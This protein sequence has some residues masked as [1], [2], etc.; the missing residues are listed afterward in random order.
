VTTE[1]STASISFWRFHHAAGN[2]DVPLTINYVAGQERV[3]VSLRLTPVQ[4]AELCT[5]HQVTEVHI[6]MQREHI[7][8]RGPDLPHVA[9]HD[10]KP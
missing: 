1:V 4:F 3:K 5:G 2:K 6:V 9:P 10:T 7:G 8:M